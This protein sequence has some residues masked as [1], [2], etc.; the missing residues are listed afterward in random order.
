[1]HAGWREQERAQSDRNARS[2][3]EPMSRDEAL[4]VLGL[5]PGTGREQ[6]TEAHRRLMTKLHPNHGGTDYLASKIN[7]ARGVLLKGL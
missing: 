6:I 1:M 2:S 7:T 5:Q 3:S 4:Q